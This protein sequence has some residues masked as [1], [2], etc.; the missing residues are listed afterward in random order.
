MIRLKL[1]LH[2]PWLCHLIILKEPQNKSDQNITH[3]KK[4][5]VNIMTISCT[6]IGLLN[7]FLDLTNGVQSMNFNLRVVL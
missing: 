4:E 2:E 5:P 3:L 6:K 7:I 1:F